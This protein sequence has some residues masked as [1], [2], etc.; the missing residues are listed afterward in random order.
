[1][2]GPQLE[3]GYEGRH[4]LRAG[5]GY[6]KAGMEK[7]RC[8]G[9]V[10]CNREGLRCQ[11]GMPTTARNSLSWA[12]GFYCWG[13]SLSWGISRGE[14]CLSWAGG[15]SAM[16][17]RGTV[18]P[19]LGVLLLL[20]VTVCPKINSLSEVLN[21]ACREG[22]PAPVDVWEGGGSSPP[23]TPPPTVP[24]QQYQLWASQ[25]PAQEEAKSWGKRGQGGPGRLR[26][27]HGRIGGGTG[28]RAIGR[29]W[30]PIPSWGDSPARGEGNASNPNTL[31]VLWGA[32]LPPPLPTRGS[33]L[34]S[35]P[36]LP[37]SLGVLS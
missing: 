4:P 33:R 2:R 32:S 3:E 5:G 30:A 6:S 28:Q 15:A 11:G 27:L 29:A 24:Q 21:P 10:D 18:S 13:H 9:D 1:M 37:P 26:L 36:L 12:E 23:W 25:P 35:P 20:G 22:E 34:Q 16:G 8:Q 19:R 17:G 7:E 14:I 31:P